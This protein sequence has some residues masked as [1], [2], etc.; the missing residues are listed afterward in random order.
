MRKFASV[1]SKL[2]VPRHQVGRNYGIGVGGGD[3]DFE[4]QLSH[5]YS[6]NYS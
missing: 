2:N 5:E 3:P 6:N 4:R 1:E